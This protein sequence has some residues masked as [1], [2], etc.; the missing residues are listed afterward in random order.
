VF[1]L[2]IPLDEA[3]F[4]NTRLSKSGFTGDHSR[5]GTRLGTRTSQTDRETGRRSSRSTGCSAP[6]Y[7]LY[8]NCRRS[9]RQAANRQCI[10]QKWAVFNPTLRISTVYSDCVFA[11]CVRL[12][13]ISHLY[14]SI[15]SKPILSRLI[16]S[17]TTLSTLIL[18][19]TTLSTLI[20]SRTALLAKKCHG[21]DVVATPP[22]TPAATT[23]PLLFLLLL[24]N[25]FD[26]SDSEQNDWEQ[27]DSEQND[28]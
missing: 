14:L 9:S 6:R 25:D 24:L 21:C 1:L 13:S 18:S 15:L 8:S 7:C 16:L 2:H 12:V 11:A 5:T 19:K 10:A 28:F 17:K 26:E 20:L 22:A 23:A 27:I 4:A 3:R